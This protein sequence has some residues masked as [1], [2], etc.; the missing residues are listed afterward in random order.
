VRRR[1][2]V[3]RVIEVFRPV[4]RVYGQKTGEKIS[5]KTTEFRVP[6]S[7]SDNRTR[8]ARKVWNIS[9]IRYLVQNF[10]SLDNARCILYYN[11][12]RAV[13]T[14]YYTILC[15]RC[16]V[17]SARIDRCRRPPTSTINNSK[18]SSSLRV[19]RRSWCIVRVVLLSAEYYRL[20]WNCSVRLICI[21]NA[22]PQYFQI[23]Q[24]RKW[25]SKRY[26][27]MRK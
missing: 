7:C 6:I 14:F 15:G 24:F 21:W 19:C 20:V 22:T 2:I 23:S 26:I 12:W 9:P 8:Y 11:V 1:S 27:H 18:N 10:G 25:H 17:S 13:Y 5:R 16:I 3:T 4:V